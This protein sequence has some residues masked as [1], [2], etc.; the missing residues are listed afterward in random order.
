MSSA[1][2]VIGTLRVKAFFTSISS[3]HHTQF[4]KLAPNPN[5]LGAPVAQWV[6]CWPTDLAKWIRYLPAGAEIFSIINGAPLHTAFY[7]QPPIVLIWLKQCW[8][9][10]KIASHLSVHLNFRLLVN[11][12]LQEILVLVMF[13]LIWDYIRWNYIAFDCLRIH[14]KSL[15]L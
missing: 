12:W 1:A 8:K 7:Y 2:V 13:T 11:N 6:K 5:F 15:T 3:S 4:W 10:H 14:I 9:G